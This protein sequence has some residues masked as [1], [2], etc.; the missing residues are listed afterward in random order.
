MSNFEIEMPSNR[1][2][3]WFF[4]GIFMLLTTYTYFKNDFL[5]SKIFAAFLFLLL[6]ITIFFTSKLQLLNKL[7][8]NLGITLGKFVS[9]IILGALFFFLI[10]PVAVIS[11]LLGRDVLLI[12]K[13][14]INTYWISRQLDDPTNF[15]DQF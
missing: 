6:I 8:F 3:G 9:P 12:K 15:R 1:K 2:F 5:L 4:S 14:K 11:R 10:S 13:R 7:W